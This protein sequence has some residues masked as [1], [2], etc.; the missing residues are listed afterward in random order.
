MRTPSCIILILLPLALLFASSACTSEKQAAEKAARILGA[1]LIMIEIAR[2]STECH[3]FFKDRNFEAL[4]ARA[5][6][7]R[8]GRERFDNGTWKLEHL[9][10]SLACKEDAPETTWQ[11]HEKILLEWREK[12]PESVTARVAH[13]NFLV[14]YAWHGRGSGYSN[15]VTEEGWR[16]HA[17][18]LTAARNLLVETKSLPTKC[19][20]LWHVLMQ[21]ALGQSWTKQEFATL[22]EEAKAQELEYHLHDFAQARFLMVRWHGEV[23]D[24]EKAAEKEIERPDGLGHEGYARVVADQRG[25]YDDI[26]KETKASWP[27]TRTGFEKL[28]KR[29]PDS[30]EI[31]NTFCRLAVIAGDK[32]LAKKLFDEIDENIITYCWGERKRFFQMRRWARF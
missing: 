5:N 6:E 2:F 19:P 8:A 16:L 21:V 11:L 22:F 7:V 1:D 12:M 29:H 15:E 17:E 23:G 3:G 10:S 20:A 14:G 30:A 4:D 27:L 25:Y 28:R 31:L 18:R 9:Y 24:W 26:F 32:Q 13:A